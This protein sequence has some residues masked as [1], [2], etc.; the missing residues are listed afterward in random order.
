MH[1][2]LKVALDVHLQYVAHFADDDRPEHFVQGVVS[3]ATGP[4]PKRAWQE[5]S[6]VDRFQNR[7]DGSLDNFI[8]QGRNPKWTALS[9]L[10]DV[11]SPHGLGAVAP[12]PQAP[13]QVL[14]IP[15]QLL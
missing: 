8:F 2:V 4:I 9:I 6:L 15:H 7:D 1:D 10:L 13:M 3:T 11:C 5:V 14:Q 12:L